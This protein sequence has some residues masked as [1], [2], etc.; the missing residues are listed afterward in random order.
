MMEL[1][2]APGLY[3]VRPRNGITDVPFSAI[4]S[5]L[6]AVCSRLGALQSEGELSVAQ[7]PSFR[8]SAGVFE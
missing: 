5:D 2:L 7:N 1:P 8:V 3:M 6:I 4:R